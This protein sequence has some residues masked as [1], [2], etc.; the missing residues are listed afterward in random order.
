MV[1][2]MA[3]SKESMLAGETVEQKAPLL[4]VRKVD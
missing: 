1:L 3:A 4:A 2:T